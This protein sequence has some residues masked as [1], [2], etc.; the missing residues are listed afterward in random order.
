MRST[1]KRFDLALQPDQQWLAFSIQ[2]LARGD[3]DPSFAEAVFGNI[4]TFL[5]IQP[6]ANAVFENRRDMMRTVRVG[7]KTVWK[8]LQGHGFV[9]EASTFFAIPKLYLR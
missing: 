4:E 3:L 6:N 2:R 9:H 1:I 7:R 5:A 8:W